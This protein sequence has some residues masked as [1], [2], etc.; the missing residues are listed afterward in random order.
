MRRLSVLVLAALTCAP[1]AWADSFRCGQ[2]LVVEGTTR[3]E[4]AAWCGAPTDVQER[5]ALRPPIL[6]YYGRPVRIAG[7]PYIEVLVETWTY[8]LGPHK[9]MRRLTIEN[10]EV[11]EVETLGYGYRESPPRSP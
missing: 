10:G 9:L 3:G 7:G 11:V 5:H 8:N 6:W 4:V 1:A 2:R